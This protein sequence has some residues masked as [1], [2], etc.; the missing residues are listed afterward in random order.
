MTE[1]FLSGPEEPQSDDSQETGHREPE[2]GD[3]P[4]PNRPTLTFGELLEK[5]AARGWESE[6]SDT[7][8]LT[9]PERPTGSSDPSTTTWEVLTIPKGRREDTRATRKGSSQDSSADPQ[10]QA[11][12]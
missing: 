3:S 4:N 9:T 7:S 5:M 11:Q 1:L 10:Q 12:E 8:E 6:E 2:K